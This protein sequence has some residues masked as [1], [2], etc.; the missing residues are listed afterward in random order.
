MSLSLFLRD[1][2][3]L[4]TKC[5]KKCDVKCKDLYSH[6]QAATKEKMRTIIPFLTNLLCLHY[7]L[8]FYFFQLLILEVLRN[9]LPLV[10]VVHIHGWT[11]MYLCVCAIM[12]VLIYLFRHV[13]YSDG[14]IPLVLLCNY[15]WSCGVTGYLFC[16]LIYN[17]YHF[18][19][20]AALH[21]WNE[22]L[23]TVSLWKNK[24]GDLLTFQNT[25]RTL[26][27]LQYQFDQ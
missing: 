13:L 14:Q 16:K 11:C 25:G 20:A 27:Q 23:Y 9:K 10:S 2:L 5:K 8:E 6:H 1:K 15:H 19:S 12:H 17:C 18:I 24:V 4:I 21:L 22:A 7:C 3:K 26:S